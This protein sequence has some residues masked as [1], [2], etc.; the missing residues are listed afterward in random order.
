MWNCLPSS[1]SIE[2]LWN[3]RNCMFYINNCWSWTVILGDFNVNI[4][5]SCPLVDKLLSF[6]NMLNMSQLIFV[7]DLTRIC[8]T[9]STCIDLVL[10]SDTDRITHSGVIDSSISDSIVYARKRTCSLGL[11]KTTVLKYLKNV[12]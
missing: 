4:L 8:N 6:T 10:V 11:W 1:H 7:H 3:T 12:F 2:L 5:S 9:L